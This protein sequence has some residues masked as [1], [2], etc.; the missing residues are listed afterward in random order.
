MRS[1]V[2]DSSEEGTTRLQPAARLAVMVRAQ[3]L[4]LSP[5][6]FVRARQQLLHHHLFTHDNTH[7]LQRAL[8][9]T[10]T[11]SYN[12]HLA[13]ASSYD[14]AFSDSDHCHCHLT[15]SPQKSSLI[16]LSSPLPISIATRSHLPR[17]QANVSITKHTPP[18]CLDK[19][20]STSL[21]T[22]S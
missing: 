11:P 4:P 13:R 12:C 7:H 22:R 19:E 1:E 15:A 5:R 21:S 16:N 10:C 20:N 18:P 6:A 14:R 3:I 8:L 2:E 17:L 9:S